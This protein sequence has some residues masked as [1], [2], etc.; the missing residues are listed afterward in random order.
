[1]MNN[2][3][4]EIWIGVKS[5]PEIDSL[6]CCQDYG[7]LIARNKYEPRISFDDATNLKKDMEQQQ[8]A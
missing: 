6:K 8:I 7:T 5:L 2:T 3:V 4:F 1:M